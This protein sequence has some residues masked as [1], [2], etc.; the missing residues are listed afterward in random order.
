M[1]SASSSVGIFA[2]LLTAV[3]GSS[4][5]DLEIV[6][7]KETRTF[8][9]R[10]RRG[11][12]YWKGKFVCY[13]IERSGVRGVKG[14]VPEATDEYEGVESSHLMS[15]YELTVGPAT[16]GG[17]LITIGPD[18]NKPAPT[19][20]SLRL[21]PVTVLQPLEA[22]TDKNGMLFT[23]AEDATEASVKS[24]WG[25]LAKELGFSNMPV[26][27]PLVTSVWQPSEQ[28]LLQA[29]RRKAAGDLEAK[30]VFSTRLKPNEPQSWTWKLGS[31]ETQSLNVYFQRAAYRARVE[32][33]VQTVDGEG[34]PVNANHRFSS[35]LAGYEDSFSSLYPIPNPNGTQRIHRFLYNI[36][37]DRFSTDTNKRDY[38]LLKYTH[39]NDE[40]SIR[41]EKVTVTA[42][43]AAPAVVWTDR[44][45]TKHLQCLEPTNLMVVDKTQ[46]LLVRWKTSNFDGTERLQLQLVRANSKDPPIELGEFRPWE[47]TEDGEMGHLL[48]PKAKLAGLPDS[49]GVNLTFKLKQ[50]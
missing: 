40:G 46:D 21:R 39:V 41:I 35:R 1:R 3:Q 17:P 7:L 26:R 49:G 24:A 18:K 48:I 27:V 10:D 28:V 38:W 16:G 8:S 43:H 13:A 15:G 29:G 4:A 5:A 6:F 32:F 25:R 22:T 30:D 31:S 50:P 11:E 20:G 47:G 14:I 45:V 37:P 9:Q 12:V 36:R 33:I 19:G 2:L 42:V 34:A 23:D 44:G